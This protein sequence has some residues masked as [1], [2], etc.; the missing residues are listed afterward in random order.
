MTTD[1]QKPKDEIPPITNTRDSHPAD[2]NYPE[3]E[4]G[5]DRQHPTAAA[6]AE[7][8]QTKAPDWWELEGTHEVSALPLAQ[9]EW[10]NRFLEHD[11]TVRIALEEML[12]HIGDA[13][14]GHL[15]PIPQKLVEAFNSEG[16]FATEDRTL[17]RYGATFGVTARNYTRIGTAL[18]LVQQ[19]TREI[20]DLANSLTREAKQA[21]GDAAPPPSIDPMDM[22]QQIAKKCGGK[23][24]TMTPDGALH[25]VGDGSELKLVQEALGAAGPQDGAAA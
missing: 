5:K 16:P 19:A 12:D 2:E 24:M 17:R 25:P 21:R 4:S 10:I 22:I 11:K 7:P 23:V 6:A 20:L 9:H 15:F 18:D 13:R 8:E 1:D 3:F 14:T